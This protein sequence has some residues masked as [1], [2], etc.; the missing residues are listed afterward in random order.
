[1]SF[2]RFLINEEKNYLGNRVGDVLTA[3]QELEQ[4]MESLGS[5]HLNR[6][7][8]NVVNQIRKILHGHWS[9][10]S[11]KYLQKLQRVAV[12]I[13]KT[14]EDKGDLKQILPTAIQELETISG[15]LGVKVNNLEAPPEQM[16]GEDIAQSD[17]E[18]TG[19]GPN[20]PQP[21]AQGQQPS[22]TMPPAPAGGVPMTGGI[23]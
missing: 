16:G 13:K 8:D 17:F 7:A 18:L 5:R 10:K 23:Q 14:I 4:D 6:L 12:A 21:G 2:K 19:D 20:P 3:A 9:S 15:E 22:Q 1:M 11:E